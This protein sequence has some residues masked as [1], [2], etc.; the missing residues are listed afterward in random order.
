MATLGQ[1]RSAQQQTGDYA[2]VITRALQLQSD[3]EQRSEAKVG[4]LGQVTTQAEALAVAEELG[5]DPRYVRVALRESGLTGKLTAARRQTA[6]ARRRGG[7]VMGAIGVLL[8]MLTGLSPFFS[9]AGVGLVIAGIVHAF[10]PVSDQALDPYAVIPV[11]GTCRVC[12]APA[13]NERATF[14]TEHQWKG[15]TG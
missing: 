5:I 8:L 10:R 6:A 4:E 14:C 13:H 15:P 9:Y 12:G 2:P 1:N 7:A 11:A 3:A